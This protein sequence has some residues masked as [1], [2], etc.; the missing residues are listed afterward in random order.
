MA[1]NTSKLLDLYSARVLPPLRQSLLF[2]SLCNR[3]YQAD[4][5]SRNAYDLEIPNPLT[6]VDATEV[7][8]NADWSTASDLDI[9]MTTISLTKQSMMANTVPWLDEKQSPVPLI[10]RVANI[11]TRG[12]ASRI[13]KTVAA[14]LV[15]GVTSANTVTQAHNNQPYL[16]SNGS[17]NAT[18]SQDNSNAKTG[19]IMQS[20]YDFIAGYGVR[21]SEGGWDATSDSPLA[22]WCVMAPQIA[23]QFAAWLKSEGLST[24]EMDALVREGRMAGLSG[25]A[26]ARIEGV[27]LMRSPRV[28]QVAG[29]RA[30]TPPYYQVLIG[31]RRGASFAALPP[32]RQMFSPAE[33]QSDKPGWLIRATWAYDSW[34]FL[35]DTFALMRIPSGTVPS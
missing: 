21:A 32:L 14:T 35:A 34:V 20:L 9:S 15:N 19:A 7:A 16:T 31:T 5:V 3:D 17:W 30:T 12:F 10:E 26:F 27:T 23:R 1:L 18:R 8:R 29:V 13:D 24:A 25:R 11:H 6:D 22:V 33:N 28:P 4:F 2:P